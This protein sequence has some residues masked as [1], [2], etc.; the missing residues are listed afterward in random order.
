[1]LSLLPQEIQ[2]QGVYVKKEI[3]DLLLGIFPYSPDGPRSPE[4]ISN[5]FILRVRDDTARLPGV[6]DFMVLGERQYAMR[7]RIDRDRGAA[8]DVNAN[9]ILTVLRAQNTQVSAG[10][11]NQPPVFSNTDG[12]YQINV[13]ALGRLTTPEEFGPLS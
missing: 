1:M 11:L 12:A 2:L 7:I 6:Q 10:A 8:S 5:Y 3:P 13:R 9:D 4:Y